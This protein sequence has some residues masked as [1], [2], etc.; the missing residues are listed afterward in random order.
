[1]VASGTS[2]PTSM[3]V[4]ATS[5]RRLARGKPGHRGILV[6]AFHAA[7]HEVDLLAEFFAQLLETRLRRRQVD[8]F[9]F[10]DQRAD[11]VS[12]LAF[13][14][15][16]TDRIF[17]F[18][19][20]G[21]RNGAGIDRLPPGRLFAQLRD[22]HVTEIGEHERA[23]DRRRREHQHVDGFAFLRQGEPLMNSEAVLFI[24]HGKREIMKCDV[25]LKQRMCSDKKVEIAE[26]QAIE[27]FLA[28]GP[29]LAAGQNGNAN[30]GG[31]GERC[32]RCKMLARK[33][34]GRR[35]DGGLP[36]GLDDA[37][38][39]GKCN[40]RFSGADVALQQ[41]QHPLRQSEVGRDV[42]E[43]LLLRMR[44]RIR[45][46]LQYARPQA[47]LA[48]AA[49]AGLTAHMCPDK[50]KRELPG[51]QFVIGKPRPGRRSP[52]GCPPA[53]LGDEGAARP[54]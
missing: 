38:R 15:R 12:A 13:R 8:F 43:R 9:R 33:D 52:A 21:E 23:R 19:K 48:G 1:M 41:T 27:N 16:A 10:I 51:Q 14:E 3:T 2:T 53:D 4:V 24:D 22:V 11:P 35:H 42:V 46:R 34:L 37:R 17:H 45:Q 6:G 20:T 31:F 40:H 32:D 30:A 25:F 49:A 36:S 39:R 28:G 26:R 29:A 7:M 54:N 47:S 18:F 44:E 50:R 5:S